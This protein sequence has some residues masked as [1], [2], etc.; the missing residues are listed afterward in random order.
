MIN[1]DYISSVDFAEHSPRI[2]LEKKIV[3]FAKMHQAF[4]NSILCVMPIIAYYYFRRFDL[5]SI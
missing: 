1:F 4:K 3:E 5:D 2:S